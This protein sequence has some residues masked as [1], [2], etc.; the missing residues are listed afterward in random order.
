MNHSWCG[1]PRAFNSWRSGSTH[2]IFVE[3]VNGGS[4]FSGLREGKGRQHVAEV[5]GVG[6]QK[7]RLIGPGWVQSRKSGW[8]QESMPYDGTAPGGTGQQQQQRQDFFQV[9]T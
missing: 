9:M 2:P 7:A 4:G 3:D 6:K 1:S 8:N 5:G